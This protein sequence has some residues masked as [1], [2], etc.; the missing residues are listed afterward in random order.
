MTRYRVHSILLIAALGIPAAGQAQARGASPPPARAQDPWTKVPAVPTS[1]FRDDDFDARLNALTQEL[2]ADAERQQAVNTKV[3]ERFNAMDPMERMRRMQE[4]MMKDPQA[5]ARMIEASSNAG[6]SASTTAVDGTAAL[7]RLERVLEGHHKALDAAI[8]EALKPL[9]SQEQALI[10]SKTQ[11]VGE[12]KVPQFTTAAGHAEYVALIGQQNAA[13]ERA[14]A[15]YFGSQGRFQAWLGQLR[16]EVLNPQVASAAAS[17]AAMMAQVAMIETPD[18]RYQ[19][20]API[21][22]AREHVRR[23]AEISGFRHR[24]ATPVIPPP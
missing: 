8:D 10:K 6:T 18:G 16:L 14:C 24:K 13:T 9:Y 1:C 22:A 17:D 19:S 23:L 11:L 5:A 7:E 20:I 2:I 3:M 21:E 15:P 4:A 12:A